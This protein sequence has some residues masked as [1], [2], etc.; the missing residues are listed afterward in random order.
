MCVSVRHTH[1]CVLQCA[2]VF[3]KWNKNILLAV[4]GRTIKGRV[5]PED[6]YRYSRAESHSPRITAKFRIYIYTYTRI[7]VH[8][9]CRRTHQRDDRTLDRR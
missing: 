4:F 7:D 9:K 6:M 8:S 5:E 2:S 3:F 1:V